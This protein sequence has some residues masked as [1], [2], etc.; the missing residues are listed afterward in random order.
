MAYFTKMKIDAAKE[1]ILKKSHS[2]TD[3]AQALGFSSVHNFSRTFKSLTE[4]SPKKYQS[5]F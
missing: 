5:Y 3:I 4:V 1:M 2:M